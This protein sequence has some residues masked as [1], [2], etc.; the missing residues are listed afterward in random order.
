MTTEYA[1]A[2]S[3]RD[4]PEAWLTLSPKEGAG[5]TVRAAPASRVQWH[6]QVAHPGY[7]CCSHTRRFQPSGLQPRLFGAIEK[8]DDYGSSAVLKPP[9]DHLG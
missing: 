3:R 2:I 4:A 7:A 1:F 5:K 9:R 6:K 8:G